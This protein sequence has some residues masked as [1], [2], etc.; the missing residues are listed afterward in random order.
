MPAHMM[1]IQKGMFHSIDEIVLFQMI[2]VIQVIQMIQ[3]IQMIH[4]IGLVDGE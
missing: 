3:M 1:M 2:Q 4:R